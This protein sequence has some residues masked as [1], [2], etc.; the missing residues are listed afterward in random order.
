MGKRPTN[1]LA[2]VLMIIITMVNAINKKYRW[3]KISNNIY[4]ICNLDDKKAN[5]LGFANA[6]D[7]IDIIKLSKEIDK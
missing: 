1:R 3:G 6:G 2:L 7:A 5:L 4:N